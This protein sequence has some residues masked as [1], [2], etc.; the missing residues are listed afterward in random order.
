[1]KAMLKHGGHLVL[2]YRD[3]ARVEDLEF[4]KHGFTLYSPKD[5]EAILE[6]AGFVQI[7]TVEEKEDERYNCVT[8]AITV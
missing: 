7:E 2:G 4:T 1:M 6:E 3:K 8:K 5:L